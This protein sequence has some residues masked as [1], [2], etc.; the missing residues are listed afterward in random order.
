MKISL[1]W[2]KEFIDI[3]ESPQDLSQMLTNTGLEVE[4]IKKIDK[5]LG[6]LAGVVI[7]EVL[8][9][10]K[11]PNADKL[12][13]TTIDIG[14]DKPSSIVCGAP[15]VLQGQK[16]VVATVNSTLYPSKGKP[17]K[18]KKTKIRG[19][20]SQGMICAEDEIGIGT[21][22]DGIMV[23]ETELPN[24]TPIADLF[25]LEEDWV[26]EIGLTPN[27]GDATS[28]LG[29]ARDIYAITGR[30]V[31]TPNAERIKPEIDNP[32]EV[33]VED[34]EGVPRYSGV[35]IRGIK[36]KESP[37]WLKWRLRTIGVEPINNIVD[38]TNYMCHGWG[39]PM[40]AFD[41]DQIKGGKV[42]VRTMN[43]DTKFIT[44][45]EKERTLD[46]RDIMICDESEAMCIGGVFGGVK[47]AIKEH[48]TNIFLESA[49]FS[50]EYIRNTVQRHDLTTDASFRYERGTDPE[51]TLHALK[52][53][54]ALIVNMAGGKIASEYIDIKKETPSINIKTTFWNFDRLIGEKLHPTLITKT[55][56]SLDISCKNKTEKGF[57]AVVP[58]YRN[59][60]TREADLVEE[61]L[62][63]YGFN[64]IEI[65][66]TSSTSFLAESNEFEP[67]RV[68]NQ[69]THFL[70]GKG[71]HEI[72]TN[73]IVH[74]DYTSKIKVN[75]TRAVEI[76]NKSSKELAVMKTS[77]VHSGLE[78][79]RHN[80]N[81]Q[82]PTQRLFEFARTYEKSGNAFSE[83]EYLCLFLTGKYEE[84]TWM[85]ETQ[86]ATFQD[87][88]GG[89]ISTLKSL[90]ISDLE[91]QALQS[92]ALF[93]TG[94]S[95]RTKGQ[96]IGKSGVLNRELTKYFNIDQTVFYSELNWTK[97]I[98]LLGSPFEYEQLSK[99]PEVRRDLSLIV[100][101]SINYQH[102]K[103]IAFKSA[104]KLLTRI[105]V[106]SIYQGDK[107]DEG[108]K[109]YAVSFFLQTKTKTLEE[110]IINKVM[111]QLIR[112]FENEIGA[113][114]RK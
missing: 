78:V 94:L 1:N 61:V 98:Q 97:I 68:R 101:K 85:R 83:N 46:E 57:T 75:E 15:N 52:Y 33:R 82:M 109:S 19:E 5:I 14:E 29:L 50:P 11:H 66:E 110:K 13:V 9:C 73:S 20:I 22:H 63:I 65:E 102:I 64:N 74:P 40:H 54:T 72:L 76:F 17:F 113:T 4:G 80:L 16:V 27:R 100:D 36:I 91:T 38:I 108:K 35:T 92:N 30:S 81:R 45:D 105:N 39:Q 58:P 86:N 56:E 42:I 62:R 47:S 3:E 53:A 84:E 114:I 2:L 31:K 51:I 67:Y 69:L 77:P 32:I 112:D 87:L 106:F 12:K 18:I 104:K 28:H 107:I 23:L 44:L 25:K 103:Q 21:N 71:Y 41:A 26:F 37:D 10:K 49:Y 111:E 90:H 95:I 96:I 6:G 48:T 88:M 7:G 24:G 70:A 93:L 43:T 59:D 99:F 79:I 8:T 34:Q 89:V 55:L 60:V